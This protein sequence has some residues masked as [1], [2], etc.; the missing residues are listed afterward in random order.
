MTKKSLLY[1]HIYRLK[2]S[3]KNCHISWLSKRH[4]C[5]IWKRKYSY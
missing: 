2:T 5:H 3:S 4:F 1:R